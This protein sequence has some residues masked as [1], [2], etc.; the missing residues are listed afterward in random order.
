MSRADRFTPE[1]KRLEYYSDFMGNFDF[2]PLTGDIARVTN[3]A[4]VKSAL[5]NILFTG[6]GEVPYE[7]LYG[8][9]IR[10]L[11][12]D[13]ATEQTA[14]ILSDEIRTAIENHEPRVDLI[15][16]RIAPYPDQNAYELTITF[17][18]INSVENITLD[19]ILQRLR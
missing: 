16:I 7:P 18:I 9:Q 15:D 14:S 13:P 6:V 12:F 2:H 1:S 17:T 5:K 19:L 10:A 4:A 11:L 3:E 8:S